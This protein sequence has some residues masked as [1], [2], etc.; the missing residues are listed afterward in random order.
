MLDIY[1]VSFFGHREVDNLRYVEDQLFELI[2]DLLGSKEYVEFLVG[3]NGEFD[4]TVSS[5]IKRV[6][7]SY[8]NDNCCHT[9]VLPYCGK[10]KI[11]ITITMMILQ[12]TTEH[13]P[14]TSKLPFKSA[15]VRW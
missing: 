1:T 7:R 11:L 13:K 2:R 10:T 4:Q 15:T 6:K 5:A 8:R 3:R 14:L 9:L 12:F